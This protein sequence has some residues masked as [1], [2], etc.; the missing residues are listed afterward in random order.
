MRVGVVGVG[1]L[2]RHHARIYAELPDVSLV[3][4]AD[5]NR[6][7]ADAVASEFGTAACYR[8]H[9]LLDRVDAVSVAVPT[10][11]HLAVARDFLERG[12]PT[13][14]EKPMAASLHEA[15]EIVALAERTG[16][17]VQVGHTE[18]FNPAVD[19]ARAL[20]TSP[21]FI[22]IHRLGVFA[23]RSLDIDVVFD[24]MIHDLD[25]ILALVNA[26][27][28][29]IDAVGVPVLT[30]RIDIA[31][32]RLR[33]DSGCIVNITASRISKDRVRKVRVFQ[34]DMYISIDYS[35]Q[36]VEVYRLVR[37]AGPMP[38]ITA[39]KLDVPRAEPLKREL[40]DFLAAAAERRRPRVPPRDGRRALELATRI[41]DCIERGPIS[42]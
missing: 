25:V 40:E 24:L 16:A 10:D 38:T 39:G 27:V 37:G 2:G 34:P 17:V 41:A 12:I 32:A 35:A 20:I 30:S 3:G 18:R 42:R 8:H 13:L 36:E 19:A 15:D 1:S 23:P 4:V 14:I 33:F 7:R 11:S 21:R 22:E 5:I 28:A 31:N 26:E 6:D 29:S 9:D